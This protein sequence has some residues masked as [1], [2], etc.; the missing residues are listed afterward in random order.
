MNYVATINH[1]Q[2]EFLA[3]LSSWGPLGTEVSFKVADAAVDLGYCDR[4][5]IYQI[6]HQ[7]RRMGLAEMIK[8]DGR[9]LGKTVFRCFARPEDCLV[10]DRSKSKTRGVRKPRKPKPVAPRVVMALPR[11]LIPYVG[12]ERS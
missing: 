10:E 5:T 11:H 6:F 12:A 2:E 3:Y 1:A 4:R 8:G 9:R 7:L